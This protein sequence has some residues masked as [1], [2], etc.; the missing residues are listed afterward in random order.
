GRRMDA[1][2]RQFGTY[3]PSSLVRIRTT[4]KKVLRSLGEVRDLD[5]A[6]LELD[7]FASELP[8]SDLSSLEPLKEHLRLERTRARARMLSVLDSSA[9]QKDFE[10]L[11][12]ALAEPVVETPPH[13]PAPAAIREM[14]RSRYKKVRK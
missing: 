12:L 13:P 2:L 1:I 11:V 9:V 10:K 4:L 6:L 8:E 14:I 3:L 7:D 5:V